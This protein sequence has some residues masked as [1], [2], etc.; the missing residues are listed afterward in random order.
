MKA[1]IIDDEKQ[2]HEALLSLLQ[3]HSDIEVAASGFNVQ[4]GLGLIALH[5]PNL[6]FLD[7]EMPDGTGFDL[8]QQIDRPEFMVIFITAHNEYAISAI[9]FGAL[10]YLL[11]PLSQSLLT[12]ALAR[13]RERR[14]TDLL[15]ER[16]KLVYESYQ[17]APLRH[18]P[19]RM[20]VSTLEGIHFIP[21]ADVVRLEAHVNA[22]EIV[23]LHAKK[24]M[25]A[26]Q[27]IG[28]YEEQF[29][30]YLQFLRVHRSHIVNLEMVESY[31]R[32]DS[33]LQMKEGSKVPVARGKR[34]EL[35]ELLRE[36]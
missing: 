19:T 34:D 32:G 20:T 17:Q 36:L 7:I 5:Q 4:E 30:P 27:N 9:R 3:N 14:R 23:Y 35:L 10:D 11:K 18:L 1:V 26:A 25:I 33:Y 31:Y 13:A 28:A 21:V 15:T 16:L 8:L 2:S 6:I 22:T 12:E 24:R 29:K